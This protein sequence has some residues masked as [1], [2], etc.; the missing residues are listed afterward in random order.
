ML[1]DIMNR[2]VA[3]GD[4][5][6]LPPHQPRPPAAPPATPSTRASKVVELGR[7]MAPRI[8]CGSSASTSPCTGCIP[9]WCMCTTRWPSAC[10]TAPGASAVVF[11]YHCCGDVNPYSRRP[12]M[13]CA[14]SQAVSADMGCSRRRK[15]RDSV[16]RHRH[17]CHSHAPPASPRTPPRLVQIGSLYA[18]IKGQHITLR[19]LAAMRHADA[20]VDFYG[21]GHSR[22]D[23]EALTHEL[24]LDKRVRFMGT[25][26]RRE[27][28]RCPAR[29]RRGPCC[30]RS[31]KRF[32]PLWPNPWPPAYLWWPA[33]S[34]APPKYSP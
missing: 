1:V 20:T 33:T 13:L 8:P 24:A 34:P 22:A 19:A 14:I 4:D 11:T 3:D 6:T 9:T 2:Q 17:L 29:L 30:P 31:T 27:L 12:D 25:R 7:K 28:L 32:G 5:V 15:L 23:L 18:D 16:Q 21:D 10:S 26:S